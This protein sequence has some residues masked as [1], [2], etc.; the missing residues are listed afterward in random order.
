MLIM[1]S[2]K[3]I[4]LLGL[5][6]FFVLGFVTNAMLKVDVQD[7]KSSECKNKY[8]FINP[9]L[10]CSITLVIKKHGYVELESKLEKLINEK[11]ENGQVQDVAIYFRDLR[12]G[13]VFGINENDKFTPASLLKLPIMLAY[14]SWADEDPSILNER[15]QV[16]KE[17]TG[18]AT[19]QIYI[20]REEVILGQTYTIDELIHHM[21]VNSDNKASSVLISEMLRRN[22]ADLLARTYRE[23][24]MILPEGDDSTI[25]HKSYASLFRMLYNSSYLSNDL[26]EKA[27]KYLSENEFEIGLKN[28]IPED[29]LVANKFGER[30]DEKTI[31]EIEQFHDC[32]VIYYPSNPYVLCVMTKG[33]NVQVLSEFVSEIS[34]AVYDEVDSRRL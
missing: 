17:N 23:A 9:Q 33:K 25:S 32:G 16:T 30:F 19:S 20:P 18:E 12:N 27:L 8:N 14:F 10:G 6:V 15:V 5:F 11:K 2:R 34:K 1:S 21:I 29:V 7:G 22:K 3:L 28:G 26:S 13:P 24:G 31:G 4:V